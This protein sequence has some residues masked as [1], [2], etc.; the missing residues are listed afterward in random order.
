M[1]HTKL[2]E[3]HIFRTFPIVRNENVALSN[4]NQ[5]A[6]LVHDIWTLLV[7][8]ESVPQDLL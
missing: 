1:R 3:I 4:S 8:S 6:A 2:I 5:M 7:M